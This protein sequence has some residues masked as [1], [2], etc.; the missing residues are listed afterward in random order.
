MH[1]PTVKKQFASSQSLNGNK[2]ELFDAKVIV[3]KEQFEQFYDDIIRVTTNN[4]QNELPF[5]KYFKD[6][7]CITR[8]RNP[9]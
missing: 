1:L 4:Q 6:N 5:I 9:V 8:K 3:T 2:N 7:V